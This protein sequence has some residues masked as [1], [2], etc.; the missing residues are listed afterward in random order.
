[1]DNNIEKLVSQ[2]TL[3]E[4]ASLLSGIDSWH[5]LGIDRLG[6]PSIMMADGP[7]GLRRES[8]K[9][10]DSVPA[11]CFPTGSALA[12][13]WD[14]ALMNTLGRALADECRSQGISI[15]LGPAANIKR[16]PLCGRNFEY[17]SEDPYL[18]SRTAEAYIKGVQSGG[19]GTS[20]KHFAAN[21]KETDR[22]T[23]DTVVDERTLR[24]IYLASFETAVKRAK[25]W[26]VMCAYNKLN[27]EF[28]SEN[29]RLLTDILREDWGFDGFVMSDWGAVNERD[30]GVSAGLDL[31]MPSS[32]GIGAEKIIKAVK[33]GRLPEKALD[34]CA[35]RIL[36]IVFKAD[37]AK[38]S[39]PLE[40]NFTDEEHHALARKI[41]SQCMVLL[42]N[43]GALPLA[44]SGRIAVIGAFAKHPRY[45]GG[46]S[47]HIHP[48]MLDIP[49]D[50]IK[51]SAPELEIVYSDGYDI[52]D[53]SGIPNQKLI[54]EAVIAAQSA[55]A[56]VIFA[57]LPD[58]FESE[59]YDRTH[60]KMPDSHNMLITAVSKVQQNTI[61][62]LSNG[63]PVEMPWIDNVSAVL[64]A[65]LCGQ[66]SG[67]AAA[68]IL[69]GD[70]NPSGKLAETFPI[71]LSDNPSYLN[72]PGEKP[73]YTEYREGIFVGYR[74]Y[75]KKQI[76]PLF[77]FGHGLSYTTF[78]YRNIET[79]KDE[80]SDSDTLNVKVTV[81]N[82]GKVKGKEIVQ[83][84]IHDVE[85]SIIRPVKELR[86]FEKIELEPGEEKSVC[87]TLSKRDFS[88]FDTDMNDFVVESGEFEILAGGSS[89]STPLSKKI[90]FHSDIFPHRKYD[91]LSTFGEILRN[92][93]TKQ[94]MNEFSAKLN[95]DLEKDVNFWILEMPLRNIHMFKSDIDDAELDTLIEKLNRL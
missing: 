53:K 69:F 88:Y 45:Q 86:G 54:D 90:L 31:E 41:A 92:P 13:S 18:S 85:S 57:G 42:K 63:S 39:F 15:L 66:A 32:N 4:K 79:D 71:K 10:N 72:F 95:F 80:I 3:E 73:A 29:R 26:T 89:A 36:N 12:C 28:C 37:E 27:G 87:F 78:E 47:S 64:E 2:M 30:K 44:K 21:N 94:L 35:E 70:V 9:K 5:T 67:G 11:T 65:Y 93:A 75:E 59:G 76:K 6:I 16:S 81:A 58:S 77:P 55:D 49:I 83:L 46:G 22:M 1:M 68:D 24:E 84:Y 74:Y 34:K 48:T 19:V 20:L 62:V 82:I 25:P 23:T 51:K 17:Y 8:E 56:A 91:R 14:I 40:K 7:H 33:S 50:E 52:D 60:M 61:V 38:K 43:D